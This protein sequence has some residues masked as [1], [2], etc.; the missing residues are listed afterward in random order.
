VREGRVRR[1]KIYY[2]RQ[3]S[4]KAARISEKKTQ[5]TSTG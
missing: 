3:L 1:A 5:P 2:L 4:G